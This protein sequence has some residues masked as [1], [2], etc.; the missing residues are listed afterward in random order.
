MEFDA[1]VRDV[2][3]MVAKKK[4]GFPFTQNHNGGVREGLGREKRKAEADPSLTIPK[5]NCVWGPVLSG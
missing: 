2:A 1:N 5:L 3:G 4:K